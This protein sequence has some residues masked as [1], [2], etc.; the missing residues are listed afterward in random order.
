MR[1]RVTVTVAGLLAG[2]LPPGAAA[3][4]GAGSF[5]LRVQAAVGPFAFPQV[6]VLVSRADTG[7]PVSNLGASVGDG[8]GEISLPPGWTLVFPNVP[9]GACPV[10][11]ALFV[12]S[13]GGRYKIGVIE[14]CPP[15]APRADGGSVGREYHIVV[16]LDVEA[17]SGRLRGSGLG[18]ARISLPVIGP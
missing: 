7:A 15:G 8:S 18:V 9:P 11:P 10:A 14:L 4:S 3:Q 2:L 5:P 17:A 1:L 12:N 6:S 16:Q 13:G